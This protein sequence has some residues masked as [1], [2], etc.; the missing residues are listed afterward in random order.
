M[1]ISKTFAVESENDTLIVMPLRSMGSLAEESVRPELDTI[2][3]QI[4]HPD[5]RHAVIDLSE[6][7]YFGTSMLEAMYSIWRRI[8]DDEGKMVLCNVST[9]GREILRV[10]RFDTLW[11]ICDSREE[12]LQEVAQ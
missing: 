11:P 3:E 8:R 1:P 12:A 5:M 10:S 4:R 2:L 7:S 6:I 9:M